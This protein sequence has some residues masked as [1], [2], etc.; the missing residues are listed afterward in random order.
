MTYNATT[1]VVT[2][3]PTTGYTGAASFN[4]TI[5][6]GQSSSA[7]ALV[8]LTVAVVAPTSTLFSASSVPT[9]ITEN[10]HS[11]VELGLKFQ[12]TSAGQAT[13]VRFY[14]GPQN[15]GTHVGNLWSSAGAL[16]ASVTFANETASGWQQALFTTPVTLN[17]G[18]VY[19]I[20]YHTNVGL[21][22]AD[23]NFFANAVTN[24]PLM[25][26]SDASA[27]GNGVY[28]YGGG[29]TFPSNSFQATN[30]W[31]DVVF[32]SGGSGTLPPPV[33]VNDSGFYYCLE[34]RAFHPGGELCSP[35]IQIRTASPC[36]SALWAVRSTE[37][38]PTMPLLRP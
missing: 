38:W 27:G 14:K 19:V 5:T 9:V 13:G 29:S 34:Y 15:T 7:P 31:V 23:A 4:Y 17:V 2:F 1:Q 36:Q 21:Y 16:L 10:D 32:S 26:P 8:S 33:A 22:S 20:S 12:V 11:A 35:T 18:T 28:S 25:A 3:T 37:R 6:N 24:G 30:Y